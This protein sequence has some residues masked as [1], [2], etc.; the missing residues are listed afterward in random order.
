MTEPLPYA[1]PQYQRTSPA[2]VGLYFGMLGLGLIFL[3]GCFTIGI[4]MVQFSPG[5]P[6]DPF[7]GSPAS[8]IIFLSF[9][10]VV[11]FACFGG[12]LFMLINA[13]KRLLAS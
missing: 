5:G 1:T 3:G 2:T 10:Y 6:G 13:V 9:L 12:G 7:A 4:M 11:A 8:R